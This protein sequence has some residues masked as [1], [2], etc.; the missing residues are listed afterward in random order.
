MNFIKC[1]S[2]F[3]NSMFN[4]HVYHVENKLLYN[5]IMMIFT[6]FTKTTVH[7]GR[8]VS[9]LGH[10]IYPDSEQTSRFPYFLMA[11]CSTQKQQ[12]CN[13]IRDQNHVFFLPF[14]EHTNCYITEGLF[15]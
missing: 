6:V 5:K 14:F 15:A 2:G 4:L 11:V 9:Q 12:T 7:T 3:V 1:F 10:I 8:H 13:P